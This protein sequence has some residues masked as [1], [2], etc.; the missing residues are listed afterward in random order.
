MTCG[1][2]YEFRTTAVK[3]IHTVEDFEEIGKMLEGAKLY[4]L[5]GFRENERILGRCEGEP[6]QKVSE[7]KSSGA[8]LTM[9]AFSREEMEAAAELAGKYIQRVELRGSY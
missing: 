1:V 9:E 3:G 8:G 6:A 7:V 5:Q 2:D 4:F